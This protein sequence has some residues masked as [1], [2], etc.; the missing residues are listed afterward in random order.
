M[1]KL[2]GETCHAHSRI[3][4]RKIP[5]EL[6]VRAVKEGQRSILADRGSIQYTLGGVFGVRGLSLIVITSPEGDIITAYARRAG[7]IAQ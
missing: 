2:R 7:R 5:E 6:I 3:K 1:R 4:Q